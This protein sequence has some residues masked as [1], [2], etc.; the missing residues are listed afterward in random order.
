MPC[1][2]GETLQRIIKHDQESDPSLNI[3]RI[4]TFLLDSVVQ[5]NGMITEGIFR[6]PGDADN[7]TE[8][9]LK[10]DRGQFDQVLFKDPHVPA[11][12]LK[13]WFRELD[14]PLIPNEFYDFAVE[15][16]DNADALLEMIQ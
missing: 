10:L 3:P 5:M 7:I 8:M 1:N 16:S 6:V 15:H 12:L 4:C 13:L 9:K 11:A 14:E 2:Y